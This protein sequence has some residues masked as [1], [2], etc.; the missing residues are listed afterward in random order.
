[1]HQPIGLT[2]LAENDGTLTFTIT[3]Y[4]TTDDIDFALYELPN[5]IHNCND[6]LVL[7]L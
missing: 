6:K 3:P 7:A 2:K 1:M 5:G 4:D